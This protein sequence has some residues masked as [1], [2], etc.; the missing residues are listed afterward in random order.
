V[1]ADRKI[2]DMMN[3][4]ISEVRSNGDDGSPGVPI[5]TS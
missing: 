4:R 1:A 2:A 3:S 5:L